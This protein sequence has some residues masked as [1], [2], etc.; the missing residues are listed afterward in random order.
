MFN[1]Y[2][3]VLAIAIII[4]AIFTGIAIFQYLK[5]VLIE[6]KHGTLKITY[7]DK[8]RKFYYM[9]YYILLFT[10]LML[11]KTLVYTFI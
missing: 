8:V 9:G 1:I 3:W 7:S 6:Y 2:E 10:T 11:G 5:L 4:S